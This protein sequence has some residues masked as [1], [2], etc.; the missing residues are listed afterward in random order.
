MPDHNALNPIEPAQHSFATAGSNPH[1]GFLRRYRYVWL[2]GVLLSF[3]IVVPISQ[4]LREALAPALPPIAEMAALIVIL[5]AVTF[6]VGHK[7]KSKA[8]VISIGI[9]VAVM[10]VFPLPETASELRVV[11]H[12]LAIMFLIFGIIRILK[13][14]FTTR[15]VTL[16]LLCASLCVYL[17][18]GLVWALAFS[19]MGIVNPLAFTFTQ[20]AAKGDFDLGLDSGQA[21]EAIYFSFATLTT[22]GYGDI[23]PSSHASRLLTV[24]EAVVAQLY[25][26]VLVARLVGLHI[27]HS[28]ERQI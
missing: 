28:Q 8:F 25:L 22:L 3:F 24:L 16:D 21:A 19:L 12:A 13:V 27:V 15:H 23:V 9:L 11:R 7:G 14:I 20:A 10:W 5:A 17:L 4:E 2:F 18:L 1:E 26:T 6:S